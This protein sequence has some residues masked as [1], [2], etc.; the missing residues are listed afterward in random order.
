MPMGRLRHKEHCRG[1]GLIELIMTLVAISLIISVPAMLFITGLK[2]FTS[3]LD[4]AGIRQETA[5][6]MELL[7]REL[8]EAR[9]LTDTQVDSISFWW[10]DT[11]GDDL[12]D[13]DETVTFSWS[14]TPGDSFMRGSV[15]LTRDVQDLEFTYRDLNNTLLTPSPTL[16]LVERDSL[17]WIG[18]RMETQKHD[19]TLITVLAIQ[20]KNLRQT[21]GPW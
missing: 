3:G 9:E 19:E 13:A 2:I 11:D 4:R 15:E 12:R 20:S 14:G 16:S 5:I 7:S 21:R 18:V 17:R 1:V 10:Q 8:N 6:G